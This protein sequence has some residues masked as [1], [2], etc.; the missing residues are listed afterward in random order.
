MGTVYEAYRAL[1]IDKG[2][3]CLEAREMTTPYYCYPINAEPI[4]F[5]GCILYCFLPEYGEMV[6]ACNPENYGDR[7]VYPLAANFADFIRLVLACGSVNPVE[8]I[9]GMNR[10]QFDEHTANVKAGLTAEQ[11]AAGD[12]LQQ[13]LGLLPMDDPFEY[14]KSI[15][16][17][18][19]DSKIQYS[20]EYYE[21]TGLENPKGEG[22][23]PDKYLFGTT[24]TFTFPKKD[25]KD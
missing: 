1:P 9:V 20:D 11:K 18:F 17:E 7:N 21:V 3:F 24:V 25:D 2:L 8:Q 22:T 23:A 14:V 16:K 12:L 4:G 10:E 5:E 19:D 15:Q 6:F 13:K